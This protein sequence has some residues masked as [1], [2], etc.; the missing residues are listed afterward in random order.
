MSPME[1]SCNTASPAAFSM[2]LQGSRRK[3]SDPV[4]D[5]HSSFTGG[6]FENA[7]EKSYGQSPDDEDVD[8]EGDAFG[9][10]M[11]L[12]MTAVED[13]TEQRAEAEEV[14][15]TESPN[16]MKRCM[17]EADVVSKRVCYM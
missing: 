8:L 16:P 17:E 7:L 10:L 2:S 4:V 12:A 1:L 9:P 13:A 3:M 14:M 15:L 11:A 6:M 5:L